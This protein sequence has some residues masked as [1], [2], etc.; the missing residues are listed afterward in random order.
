MFRSKRFTHGDEGMN[1]HQGVKD[2]AGG[3]VH[4]QNDRHQYKIAII[5]SRTDDVVLLDARGGRS[6]SRGC[7]RGGVRSLVGGVEP[8]D[9]DDPAVDGRPSNSKESFLAVDFF[10]AGAPSGQVH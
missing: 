4:C 6:S 9:I 10:R 1:V 3:T 5:R 7:D 8:S 2:E